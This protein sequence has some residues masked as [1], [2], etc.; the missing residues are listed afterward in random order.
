MIRFFLFFILII[1]VHTSQAQKLEN[2]I[3][4]NS[5]T[6]I[7][8]PAASPRHV[9]HKQVD[10]ADAEPYRV[11]QCS[12]RTRMGYR[13][14]IGGASYH[15][16]PETAAWLGNHGGPQFNFILAYDNFNIGFRFKPWSIDPLKEMHINGESVPVL[17]RINSIKLDYYIGYSF[18]FKGLISTEPYAGYNRSSF[19]VIN[20]DELGQRFNFNKTGGIIFGATFNKYFRIKDY[21]YLSIFASA[22]Y[23]FTDFA[24]VHSALDKGYFEW[25]AGI[26]AKGFFT[27]FF[28]HRVD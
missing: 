17:A 26:A 13:V 18:D 5:D 16:G 24:K 1:I 3:I 9:P 2:H 4:C 25:N 27:R 22:G 14:E 7:I 19:I 6:L 28:H 10:I 8:I 12:T 21:E 11:I 15:Y 20:E 23:S